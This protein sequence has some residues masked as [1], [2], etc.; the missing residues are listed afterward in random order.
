MKLLIKIVLLCLLISPFSCIKDDEDCYYPMDITKGVTVLGAGSDQ[1]NGDYYLPNII[2]L[3]NEYPVYS[4]PETLYTIEFDLTY[5]WSLKDNN[6]IQYFTP[7]CIEFHVY[8]CSSY[9]FVDLNGD[10]PAPT[11]ER[12]Y[13]IF[14]A[15]CGM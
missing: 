5:G 3:V 8:N 12:L 10:P 6:V 13:Y 1:Y 11:M 2:K 9:P 4:K 14:P 15:K 7:G